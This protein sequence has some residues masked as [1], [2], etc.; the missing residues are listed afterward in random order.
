MAGYVGPFGRGYHGL[1]TTDPDRSLLR[2]ISCHTIALY[3]LTAME[4]RWKMKDEAV[5]KATT[6]LVILNLLYIFF[7]IARWA[8]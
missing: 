1:A 4:K 6:Y 5:L 8:W 2:I 3:F 7:Q